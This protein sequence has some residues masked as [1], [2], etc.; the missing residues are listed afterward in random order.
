[1]S[2]RQV[3]TTPEGKFGQ[4]IDALV[5]ARLRAQR[6][7]VPNFAADPPESDPT[8]LWMRYDGR[9]RGRY[10]NGASFTYVDYPMRSDITAPPAVPAYPP[11]PASSAAPLTY[12]T[13]WAATWSQSYTGSGT[14]RTDPIGE[15]H[16]LS[17]MDPTGVYGQQKGIAGFDYAAI[18]A[19]LAGSTISKIEL[20]VTVINAYWPTGG[21]VYFGAHALT[22]EPTT[23]DPAG[24]LLRYGSS[25]QF[26]PGSVV[27]VPLPLT[28]AQSFRSGTVRGLVFESITSDV[29]AFVQLAG[30]GSGYTEPQ[31]TVTY[32][33]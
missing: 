9:L 5:L 12:T 31:L 25:A 32:A 7:I 18:A 1:V 14:K 26:V 3:P 27:T 28:F 6:F 21:E 17:G 10:W 15:L 11:A 22:A 8:N 33:K 29:G 13:T 19:S 30:V 4:Q 23:F 20:T 2:T 16:L 24:S